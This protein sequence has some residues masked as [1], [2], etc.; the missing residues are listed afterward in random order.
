MT[1]GSKSLRMNRLTLWLLALLLP[2]ASPAQITGRVT[3]PQG[4]P[5]PYATLRLLTREGGGYAD[6]LGHFA[7]PQAQVGDSVQVTAVGY[8]PLRM[9]L[10]SGVAK[11]VL[12]AA[13]VKLA[14]V[15]VTNRS[16]RLRR[17]SLRGTGRRNL[18]HGFSVGS[19]VARHLP[20]PKP[21]RLAWMEKVVIPIF[22]G[23]GRQEKGETA[24]TRL[25]YVRIHLYRAASAAGPP[26]EEMLVGSDYVVNSNDAGSELEVD[27]R[28]DGLAMPDSGVFVGLEWIGTPRLIPTR[29]SYATNAKPS[30]PSIYF[31]TQTPSPRT[32]QIAPWR[33]AGTWFVTGTNGYLSPDMGA[34]QAINAD[35]RLEIALE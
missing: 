24:R 33:S 20:H 22:E 1:F 18:C 27:V 5:V 19:L 8:L 6:S 35:F 28:R 4:E 14:V 30:A 34:V 9:R 11:V 21:G 7:L 29:E 13:E 17:S 2:V 16:K 31:F 15:T 25:G 23:E 3:G 26:G 10:T 32:W 12:A